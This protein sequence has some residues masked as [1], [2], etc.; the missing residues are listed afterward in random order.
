MEVFYL[1]LTRTIEGME[2][3]PVPFLCIKAGMGNEDYCPVSVSGHC[4]LSGRI[5]SSFVQA[6]D[7]PYTCLF[8]CLPFFSFSI[9]RA[10][11]RQKTS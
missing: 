9:V 3:K 6:Q 1:H 5:W 4:P 10:H 7:F 2:R 8:L 11:S